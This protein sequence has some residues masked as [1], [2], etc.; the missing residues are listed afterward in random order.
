MWIKP[1]TENLWKN[2]KLQ[3][4]PKPWKLGKRE[5]SEEKTEKTKEKPE[6]LPLIGPANSFPAL[7]G[8]VSTTG[9]G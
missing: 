8:S 6:A 7:G 9:G 1:K 4:H 5:K 2:K 3:T